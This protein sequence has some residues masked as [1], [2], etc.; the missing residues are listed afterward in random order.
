MKCLSLIILLFI[1]VVSS[2]P[3]RSLQDDFDDIL[4]IVPTKEMKEITD[5]YLAT[6]DEFREVIKFLQSNKWDDLVNGVRS[7]PE[8]KDFNKFMLDAGIDMDAV[9]DYLKSV[10]CNL[11]L[12]DENKRGKFS[13]SVRG[14]LDEIEVAFPIET[15][16]EKIDEKLTVSEDFQ[17]F[18]MKV[19]SDEM[20]ELAERVSR[21]EE[22]QEINERL[23]EMHVDVDKI[24]DYFRA[25]LGWI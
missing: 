9:I 11:P 15:L 10:I 14:Y 21:L 3:L 7:S 20:K 2:K 23:I 4:N 18:Y 6:D 1:S 5:R 24:F 16:L 25:F 19:S 12:N 8:M 13:R 17:E 22:V